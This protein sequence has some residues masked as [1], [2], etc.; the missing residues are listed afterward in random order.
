MRVI[1]LV[2][3]D[4]IALK[5]HTMYLSDGNTKVITAGSAEEAILS[6]YR[7]PIDLLI[8]DIRMPRKSGRDLIDMTRM[9]YPDL[10]IMTL[11]TEQLPED[12]AKRQRVV[13]IKKTMHER[14]LREAVARILS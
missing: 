8:T 11:S 13:C 12:Y 3:D 4:R 5:V 10:P 1:L 6:M 14:T 2:D 7:Q 9:I